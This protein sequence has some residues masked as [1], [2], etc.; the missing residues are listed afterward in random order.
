MSN[1]QELLAKEIIGTT[2]VPP[3]DIHT[4]CPIDATLVL[5]LQNL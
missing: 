5:F 1:F 2:Q 3:G 4:H